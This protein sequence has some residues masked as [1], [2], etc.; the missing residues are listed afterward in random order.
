MSQVRTRKRP[1]PGSSPV[2][3]APIQASPKHNDT[4]INQNSE[5]GPMATNQYL[6]WPQQNA[7]TYPDPS[8]NYGSDPY[9]GVSQSHGLPMTPSGQLARRSLGQQL[10][11]RAD[12]SDGSN[13]SW[14]V[15]AD[16]VGQP[17]DGSLL[18]QDDDLDRRAE[19]AKRE[20]QTKR[21]QIPPFVQKLSR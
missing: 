19:L 3:T 9:N 21:K 16:G 7:N 1:A 10:V 17:A 11:S 12:Y 13:E 18:N 4:G 20:T 6:Q 14:P 15:L 2:R 8:G 5:A